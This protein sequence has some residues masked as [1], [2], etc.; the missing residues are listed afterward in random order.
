M[1]D[2]LN[3][4]KMK[5]FRL[6]FLLL[7]LTLFLKIGILPAQ[8]CEN[9]SVPQPLS[10]SVTDNHT[11]TLVMV[12][13]NPLL[14]YVFWERSYENSWSEIVCADYYNLAEPQVIIHGNGF[15]VDN[16]QVIAVSGYQDPDTLAFVFYLYTYMEGYRDIFYKVMTDTGF[17]GSAR[18][19]NTTLNESH[20]RVS[21]GG[22][23]VWQEGDKIRFSRLNWNYSGFYFEPVVTIDSGDCR[24]PD[25][26]NT[27]LYN[28]AEGFIAWEKGD[29]VNP[30]I[31]FSAW[32]FENEAWSEPMLLFE[33]GNHS[34]IRFSIGTDMASWVPMLLSDLTDEAGQYRI[35][36]YDFGEQNEFISEFAQ[37]VQFQPNLLT[38]DFFT[39]YWQMGYLAFQHDEGDG[40]SDIFSSD[41]AWLDPVLFNYCPIDITSRP[42]VNPQLFQGAWHFSYFDMIGIWETWRNGHWQL[43]SSVQPVY[44]GSVSE[45]AGEAC[46]N[47]RAYPDP[48][49]DFLWLEYESG[50]T[51]DVRVSILNTFGQLV[52]TTDAKILSNGKNLLKIE[53]ANLPAGI[54]LV[55]I[56]TGNSMECLKVVKR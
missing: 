1:P 9:W 36:G 34:G 19:T 30:E 35:S 22:G 33:D 29:P 39:D 56:D 2:M 25:I 23:M 43:F 10:D 26:Q 42:D 3:Q 6:F 11:A 37:E 21:P 50:T 12:S 24:N 48:F 41:Y 32:S 28:S 5:A 49:S 55:R 31:W 17:T 40:N 46:L 18:F 53:T 52:K 51:S 4:N 13:D 20:L 8:N 45:S 15:E 44:V 27:D 16:P 14:Y 54:Y 7:C 47:A 38:I